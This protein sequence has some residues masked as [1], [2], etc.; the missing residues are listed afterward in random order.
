VIV[1]VIAPGSEWV[2]KITVRF[3][4]IASDGPLKFEDALQAI[5]AKGIED[6]EVN[7][8]NADVRPILVRLEDL[9]L[10]TKPYVCGEFV[11]RNLTGNPP[12]ATSTGLKELSIP[13]KS[14]LGY[15]VAFAY[16]PEIRVLALEH[17]PHTLSPARV[18]LYVNMLSG[19]PFSRMPVV[20][21]PAWERY[22]KGKPRKLLITIA[23]PE[24]LA[25]VEG[26]TSGVLS[27]SSKL[28]EIFDGPVITIEVSMGHKKG[29]LNL[30]KVQSALEFFTMGGGQD[31]DIRTLRASVKPD[32][33]SAL[34]DLD[35]LNEMLISTDN[36]E[37]VGD[38]NKNYALRKAFVRVELARHL[39]YIKQVFGPQNA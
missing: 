18:M 8:G 36:L 6:R 17:S 30:E 20:A 35:F 39:P 32:D 24:N 1:P 38:P 26:D 27:A 37:L 3:H 33:E 4:R 25:A 11:R 31:A 34:E 16:I 23:N 5:N 9:D 19:A 22:K 28:K 10:S 15:Q 12:E 13:A 14:G 21:A 7:I 2:A 29:W